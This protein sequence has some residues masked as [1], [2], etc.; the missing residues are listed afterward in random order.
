MLF[1]QIAVQLRQLRHQRPVHLQAFRS[2]RAGGLPLHATFQ[3]AAMHFGG[4]DFTHTPFQMAQ[5]VGHFELYIQ[6]AVVYRAQFHADL[7]AAIG[8]AGI[9]IAGHA[10][11]HGCILF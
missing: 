7:A 10:V 1:A 11:H 8:A 2:R 3:L 9:G 4:N 5:V 6:I